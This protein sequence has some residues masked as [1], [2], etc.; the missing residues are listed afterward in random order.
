MAAPAPKEPNVNF[1]CRNMT[2]G[3]YSQ[4]NFT[5]DETNSKWIL[6][7]FARPKDAKKGRLSIFHI[8]K[9]WLFLNN[10]FIWLIGLSNCGASVSM[11]SS[12]WNFTFY[13]FNHSQ[14]F[15]HN[16]HK[17]LHL[18]HIFKIKKECTE[19]VTEFFPSSI[20]ESINNI[21]PILIQCMLIE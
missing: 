11:K 8:V 1:I 17:Y 19:N 9:C 21:I 7:Y 15:H 5:R 6:H 3:M 14:C 10:I 18:Y 20:R 4:S 12:A 16:H 13:L 2:S